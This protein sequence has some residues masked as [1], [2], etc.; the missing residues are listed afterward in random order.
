MGHALDVDIQKAY[1]AFIDSC[2]IHKSQIKN[3]ELIEFLNEQK[4]I[5][6]KQA[7][8]WNKELECR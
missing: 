7:I 4:I 5:M 6:E 8:E 3:N 1:C 2:N